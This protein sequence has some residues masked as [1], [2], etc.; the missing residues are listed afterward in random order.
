MAKGGAT[1]EISLERYGR[2][3]D[4]IA[5]LLEENEKLKEGNYGRHGKWLPD[6]TINANWICSRCG[7][8]TQAG[9]AFKIYKYCPNC[10][11]RM[12]TIND[13]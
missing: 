2:M 7:F 9:G 8:H 6:R 5:K 13:D 3:L 4:R 10:G 11:A 12:E 1:V